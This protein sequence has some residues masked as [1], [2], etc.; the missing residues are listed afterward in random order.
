MF[1]K[2]LVN[3][4]PVSLIRRPTLPTPSLASLLPRHWVSESQSPPLSNGTTT[5]WPPASPGACEN[6]H[7]TQRMWR[8]P[9]ERG[10]MRWQESHTKESS[11]Q[12]LGMALPRASWILIPRYPLNCQQCFLLVSDTIAERNR[13]FTVY[14]YFYSFVSLLVSQ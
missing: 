3:K 1:N 6:W 8:C 14:L 7:I 9:G 11:R 4:L 12:L 13:F 10:L 5:T 2:S